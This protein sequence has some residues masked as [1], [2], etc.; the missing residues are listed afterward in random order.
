MV[1]L[2]K[3]APV[4]SCGGTTMD[5]TL[6][7]IVRYCDKDMVITA[8]SNGFVLLLMR[9][10]GLSQLPRFDTATLLI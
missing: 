10:L 4:V 6:P 3:Y 7:L 8:F 2:D 9:H 5:T 1:K